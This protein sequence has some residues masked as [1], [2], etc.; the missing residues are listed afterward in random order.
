MLYEEADNIP[1]A[2]MLDFLQR[3]QIREIRCQYEEIQEKPKRQNPADAASVIQFQ[4]M[5]AFIRGRNGIDEYAV[6]TFAELYQKEMP[7]Q[8][9]RADKQLNLLDERTRK[10]MQALCAKLEE[11]NG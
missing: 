11:K 2:L 6:C 1:T 8:C 10:K 7:G 4:R 5:L 3:T 9:M